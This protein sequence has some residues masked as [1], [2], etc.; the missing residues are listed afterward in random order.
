MNEDLIA[1]RRNRKRILSEMN[2]LQERIRECEKQM[3]NQREFAKRVEMR[4]TQ[5]IIYVL[6]GFPLGQ[7]KDS[8]EYDFKRF[9]L[10]GCSTKRQSKVK[11]L[12]AEKYYSFSATAKRKGILKKSITPPRINFEPIFVMDE[13]EIYYF[14]KGSN[15]Q[16]V[17][18]IGKAQTFYL[19]K[20]EIFQTVRIPGH[21]D[22]GP[23]YDDWIPESTESRP[24]GRYQTN[25]YSHP[26]SVPLAIL[27]A[28]RQDVLKNLEKKLGLSK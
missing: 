4:T 3:R 17:M 11:I 21:E 12:N 2:V 23:G 9:P 1:L 26:R 25:W 20:E 6:E 16:A 24:T 27:S 14:D 8:Q 18:R 28:S 5:S 13:Y 22:A 7:L 15:E 10:Y 19:R